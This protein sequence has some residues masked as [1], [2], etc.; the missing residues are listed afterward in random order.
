VEI[1]RAAADEVIDDHRE[2]HPPPGVTTRGPLELRPRDRA[3]RIVG[4]VARRVLRRR[5]RNDA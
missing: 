2:G 5:T 4:G 1:I 3:R